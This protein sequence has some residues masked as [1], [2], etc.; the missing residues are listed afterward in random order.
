MT[1]HEKRVMNVC[2]Q[3]LQARAPRQFACRAGHHLGNRV[4]RTWII[5]LPA[6]DGVGGSQCST[7]SWCAV[8][9]VKKTG[10]GSRLLWSGKGAGDCRSR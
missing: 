2:A 4:E 9:V 10:I 1:T 3:I 7:Q 5:V 8:F 6:L